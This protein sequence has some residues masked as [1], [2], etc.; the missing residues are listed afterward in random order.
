MRKLETSVPLKLG[1]DDPERCSAMPQ[2]VDRMG[3]DSPLDSLCPG[4]QRKRGPCDGRLQ[5]GV[6]ERLRALN[7]VDTSP[8]PSFSLP[9]SPLPI[10]RTTD[11]TI[12]CT[13]LGLGLS[14][15]HSLVPGSYPF[16]PGSYISPC[17]ISYSPRLLYQHSPTLLYTYIS[18]VPTD[19]PPTQK[20]PSHSRSKLSPLRILC[21]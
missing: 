18:R 4:R 20:N 2:T 9:P 5:S 12:G 6:E 3:P 14:I 8:L 10:T 11:H 16:V 1:Y 19:A 15:S 17:F 7:K 21:V 13:S